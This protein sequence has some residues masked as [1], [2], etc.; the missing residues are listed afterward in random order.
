MQAL[1]ACV[2]KRVELLDAG[3]LA[4]IG[5]YKA[6]AEARGDRAVA[7]LFAGIRE[8]TL[9]AVAS[10][11]PASMQVNSI[12]KALHVQ[13]APYR[14]QCAHTQPRQQQRPPSGAG[15]STPPA[16]LGTPWPST[17]SS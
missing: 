17:T 4:A 16:P 10:R 3:F 7:V 6:S 1:R 9:A 15:A 5:A 13:H 12:R 11:M 2:E 14:G 8:A